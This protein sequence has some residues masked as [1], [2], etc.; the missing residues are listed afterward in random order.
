MQEH[1]F[2]SSS[3]VHVS[4]LL[5]ALVHMFT[6]DGTPQGSESD[7][8]SIVP[9]TSLACKWVQPHKQKDSNPSKDSGFTNYI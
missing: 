7:S 1:S 4:V 2:I 6:A 8:E 9:V 3:C 5:H